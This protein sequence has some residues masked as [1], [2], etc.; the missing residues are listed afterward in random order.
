MPAQPASGECRLKYKLYR[1]RVNAN[2]GHRVTKYG[3]NYYW[4]LLVIPLAFSHLHAKSLFYLFLVSKEWPAG[5]PLNAWIPFRSLYENPISLH[6]FPALWMSSPP[7]PTTS[8]VSGICLHFPCV[9]ICADVSILDYKSQ[10]NTS[11]SNVLLKHMLG[12][13]GRRQ[14]NAD[15]SLNPAQIKDS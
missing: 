11:W 15:H 2:A 12:S 4:F 10:T 14:D 8:V 3:C 7:S 6:L 13:F 1:Q 9:G 5:T